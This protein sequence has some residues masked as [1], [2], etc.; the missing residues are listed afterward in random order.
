MFA[1]L[2]AAL[3][4]AR[5]PLEVDHIAKLMYQAAACSGL[6]DD[7]IVQLS[8]MIEQRRRKPAS[9]FAL[10]KTKP[11]PARPEAIAK[12]RRLAAA[13]PMPPEL[14]QHFSTSELAVMQIVATQMREKGVLYWKLED[15]AEAAGVRRTTVQNALRKASTLGLIELKERKRRGLPNLTNLV[16][17][18]CKKWL[19]WIQRRGGFKKVSPK[20]T[21]D[22][23]PCISQ[24]AKPY[25]PAWK[26]TTF[27]SS[28]GQLAIPSLRSSCRWAEDTSSHHDPGG[29]I[30]S[31]TFSATRP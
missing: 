19:T 14:A 2:S 24:D 29:L 10:R 25:S 20:H 9:R 23:K 21:Q 28:L 15:I 22:I 17:V 3:A 1:Q 12:R 18:I 11:A 8:E 16:R 30:R 5:L 6:S 7:E 31:H 4:K 13:G 27:L 26:P